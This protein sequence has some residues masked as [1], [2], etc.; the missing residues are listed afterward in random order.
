MNKW[1]IEEIKKW[2]D[3]ERKKRM[4]DPGMINPP[5]HVP[6]NFYEDNLS[7]A[8][9]RLGDNMLDVCQDNIAVGYT[10]IQY[11]TVGYTTIQ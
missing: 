11:D 1:I 4:N 8:E 3:E 10:T 6:N 9:H 2:K 7:I 5:I